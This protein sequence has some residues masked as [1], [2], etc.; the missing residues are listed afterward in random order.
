VSYRYRHRRNCRHEQEQCLPTLCVDSCAAGGGDQGVLSRYS[1]LEV[2]V[3]VDP[4]LVNLPLP[5]S[6]IGNSDVF[7]S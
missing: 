3:W 4:S 7:L 1:L 6:R 5:L 2:T